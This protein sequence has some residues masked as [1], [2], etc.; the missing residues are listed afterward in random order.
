MTNR[1]KLCLSLIGF[2]FSSSPLLAN[3]F[4]Q[5][6]NVRIFSYCNHHKYILIIKTYILIPLFSRHH[7]RA[8]HFYYAHSL[9]HP[10][11]RIINIRAL[12]L[13]LYIY[14]YI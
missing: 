8:P 14:I 4:Q 6:K 2:V 9:R 3:T 11:T 13:S 10:S 1:Y 7:E 12:S 5:Q